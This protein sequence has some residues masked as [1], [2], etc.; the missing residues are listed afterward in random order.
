[1]YT[2]AQNTF[3]LYGYEICQCDLGHVRGD[4]YF[5]LYIVCSFAYTRGIGLD[6][7]R[8]KIDNTSCYY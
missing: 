6:C 4:V 8:S 3:W 7:S 1:M 5:V 2:L